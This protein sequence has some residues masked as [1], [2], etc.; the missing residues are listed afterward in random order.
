[1]SFLSQTSTKIGIATLAL[2]VLFFILCPQAHALHAIDS[3]I[4]AILILVDDRRFKRLAVVASF[5]LHKPK[6][7]P[8]SDVLARIEADAKTA[9]S[10][11]ENAVASLPQPYNK[12]AADFVV[13]G[14]KAAIADLPAPEGAIATAV[15]GLAENPS[16][17]NLI[18]TA[19]AVVNAIQ[20]ARAEVPAG[21]VP[22][23]A[24][25]EAAPAA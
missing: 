21:Y 4:S 25:T 3:A 16:T 17:S 9:I 10:F 1:M 7:K 24:T 19:L 23:P 20:T 14:F 2:A 12:V 22:A 6:E 8:M 13:A 18:S 5:F 15:V 11:V